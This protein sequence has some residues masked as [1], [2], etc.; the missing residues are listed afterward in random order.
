[1]QRV[2]HKY[3]SWFVA[4]LFLVYLINGIIYIP[5][6]SITFDEGDHYNYAVR[7]VKGHPE[8]IRPFDDASAMPISALNTLPR[9]VQQLVQ[10]SFTR[11]DHG[12]SDIINGRYVTLVIS[13]LIGL[14]VYLWSG[15]L[16][17][18]PAALFSLFLFVFCPNISAQA[19]LV[20]TDA[21]SALLTIAPLYHYWKYSK[22][23]S[24]WQLIFFS[25]ALAVAQLSK[26]SLTFLYPMFG[27]L[28]LVQLYVRSQ[29]INFKKLFASFIIVAVVQLIVLNMGFQFKQTGMPLRLYAFKSNFFNSVKERSSFLEDVSI[30]LPSPYLYG[31]DYTKSIDEMG[32]G[33]RGS[34]P[35]AYILGQTREGKGIWYYYFIS[36]LFK[37]PVPVMASFI[38]SIFLAFEK[39]RE[40]W[41]PD[42]LFLLFPILFF[43]IYFDF[44]YNSQVGL[45]HILMIFPLI[46]VFCGNLLK[47]PFEKKGR[48]FFLLAMICYSIASF[49]YFFPNLVPYTNELITDKKMAYKIVGSA[50]LDYN[51]ASESLEDYLR[52]NST[53]EYAPETARAGKFIIS[54]NDLL[55]LGAKNGY[56]WLRD[57]F[58]PTD[59]LQFT[60]LIFDISKQDLILKKLIDR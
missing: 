19:S 14:Y 46:Q 45:R 9:I 39:K 51:Q 41:Y 47:D 32:P 27:L 18:K 59:H 4:V 55:G 7:F 5:R 34:S 6:Q 58:K 10:P 52:Q 60:Y 42:A 49:Y 23:R 20:T 33:H 11:S 28:F 43:L 56:D 37:T 21:Y 50:N 2:F 57:N 13:T 40:G 26:Q 54:T 53:V 36:I 15:N 25:I 3:H 16:Y 24:R 17:G 22:E 1:M 35:K 8:K 48:S 38:V 31:L 12:A 30:P 44:F 29:R